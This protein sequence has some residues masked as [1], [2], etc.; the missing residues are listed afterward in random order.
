[1]N[2]PDYAAI[3]VSR[4]FLVAASA[5]RRFGL[6][7]MDFSPQAMKAQY[8]H[9]THGAPEP[10]KRANGYTYGKWSM[11]ITLQ[12]YRQDHADG[13]F[14]KYELLRGNCALARRFIRSLPALTWFPHSRE[15]RA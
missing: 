14:C 7:H 9:E 10:D 3:G 2:V 4:R 13:L 15:F 11:D 6:G 1:M 8:E 5:Y 12:G